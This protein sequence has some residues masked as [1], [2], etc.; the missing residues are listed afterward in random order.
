[1]C[2]CY[3][4]EIGFNYRFIP[5]RAWAWSM[6]MQALQKYQPIWFRNFCNMEVIFSKTNFCYFRIHNVTGKS[7]FFYIVLNCSNWKFL[8][9]EFMALVESKLNG[10]KKEYLPLIAIAL[11]KLTTKFHFY[12]YTQRPSL[13]D[14]FKNAQEIWSVN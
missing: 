3:F 1:M 5:K 14:G 10:A 8:V 6:S 12:A 13:N 4:A 7:I 11:K 9:V 2:E